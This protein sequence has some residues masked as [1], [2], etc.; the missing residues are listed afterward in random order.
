MPSQSIQRPTPLILFHDKVS[1]LMRNEFSLSVATVNGSGSQSANTVL[2]KSLFRMG[3]PVGGKNLFPSNI[4]GLPT[5]FTIRIHPKGYVSRR[6]H[7]E[8]VVAM[9]PD[10]FEKDYLSVCEGGIFIYNSNLKVTTENIKRSDLTEI[11]IPFKDLAQKT[12]D[13]VKMKKLLINMVYVGVLSELFDLDTEVIEGALRDQF[14]NKPN[15]IE[16][17]LTALQIGQ[18]Y[19]KENLDKST[20]PYKVQS[21]KSHNENKIL[22]DGN[23]ASALGLLFG[24]CSFMSWYPI[25]PSSSL[26]ENFETYCHRFRKAPTGENHFAVVQAEDELSAINMVIGAGW[27]GARSA[28]TTSGPGI[29]LMA[30]AAGLSYFAEVPSVIWNVQRAGPSTGLPTRTLQGD[31]RFCRNLSHGDTE[32]ILLFPANPKECFEFGQI[33]MDLAERFQTLVMVLSD[34]DLGMNLWMSDDF[35]YPKTDF[36][37]GKVLSAEDLQSVDEFA[38]YRDSDGDAIPYRT[39]PGTKHL[40]ASY[41]TRGTGHTE[42]SAYTEDNEVFKNLLTR[43]KTKINSARKVVPHP[44]YDKS[45]QANTLLVAYGSTNE[46]IPE[47]RELLSHVGVNTSYLRLRA[48]PL[49]LDLAST[50]RKYERIYVIEQNR[51][52]QM[53]QILREDFSDLSNKAFSVNQYDGLPLEANYV[54]NEILKAEKKS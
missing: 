9:N 39:L 34:L 33:S 40:K 46:V 30:E 3:L 35:E 28:T 6:S 15:A 43:L 4:A 16:P 37:R 12:S 10:S 47:V 22:I 8:V 27:A 49:D 24:G 44:I 48:T 29:S 52:S 18:N 26:A 19:A 17:N 23:S 11:A 32:H 14:A 20:F 7:N 25:T 38:R 31:V 41:F 42:S 5:W 45:P 13:S 53:L 54:F 51:D 2:L 21:N 1:G 36:D 50:F